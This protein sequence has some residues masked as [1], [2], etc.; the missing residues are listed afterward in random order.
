MPDDLGRAVLGKAEQLFNSP[1]NDMMEREGLIFLGSFI[2]YDQAGVAVGPEAYREAS[3]N[4]FIDQHEVRLRG[5]ARLAHWD[6]DK[7]DLL[8]TLSVQLSQRL[9]RWSCNAR[10]VHL[11][12]ALPGRVVA[13][14]ARRHDQSIK[15][16][17]AIAQ[18]CFPMPPPTR[19]LY[20]VTDAELPADFVRASPQIT[21]RLHE[22]G[23]GI[24]P[25]AQHANAAFV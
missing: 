25:W 15:V 11:L 12:M 7:F 6:S 23:H 19:R 18:A 10:D 22:G 13:T 2:G 1:G 21:V 14:A 17:F 3:A 4:N 16:A 20:D 5:V 8:C 9:I 24:R